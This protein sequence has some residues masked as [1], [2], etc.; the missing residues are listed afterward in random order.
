MR[1]HEA[2]GTRHKLQGTGF[3]IQYANSK[4]HNPQRETRHPQ[5][6]STLLLPAAPPLPLS[7]VHEPG[8]HHA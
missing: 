2:Q 3:Q 1:R 4:A 5:Q 8:R 6:T 7:R